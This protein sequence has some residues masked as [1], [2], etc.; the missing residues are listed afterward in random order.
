[1][2]LEE[3]KKILMGLPEYQDLVSKE[4]EAIDTVIHELVAL[5]ELLDEKREEIEELQKEN[6]ELKTDTRNR[7]I[8]C[9]DL[10]KKCEAC[11]FKE[12]IGCEY[13]ISDIEATLNN[14]VSK[15]KIKEK[16]EE[17]KSWMN[18]D[19]LALHEFQREAQIDVLQ[20]LLKGE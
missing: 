10:V 15:D 12:C 3:A 4:F 17:I 20:E 2:E 8:G 1:M 11:D 19:C 9:R 16:I 18:D 5:Q 6:E 14:F 13:S 7:T